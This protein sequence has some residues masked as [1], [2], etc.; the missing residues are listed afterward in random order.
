MGSSRIDRFDSNRVTHNPGWRRSPEQLNL[1]IARITPQAWGLGRKDAYLS[2][3][4]TR[5]NRTTIYTYTEKYT[6]K[7]ISV[8]L[9]VAS[10]LILSA[11]VSAEEQ[12]SMAQMDG[13]TAGGSA[14]ATAIAN[15]FGNVTATATATLA[16]VQAVGFVPGQVGQIAII[17]SNANADASAQATGSPAQAGGT[18]IA[19][20][21]AAGQTLGSGLSDTVSDT[22]VLADSISLFAGSASSNTSIASSVLIG[23]SSS[24]NSAAASAA[25]LS[26]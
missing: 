18:A 11:T 17:G 26:N 12:L 22:S 6:M 16:T 21:S 25:A 9:G 20:G 23:L 4:N 3:G 13:V 19:L 2:V 24:A 7:R 15:A 14:V 5:C 10:L 8:A 1:E